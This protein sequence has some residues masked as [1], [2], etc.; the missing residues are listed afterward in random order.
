MV[1]NFWSPST[2]CWSLIYLIFSLSHTVSRKFHVP[3]CRELDQWKCRTIETL[4]NFNGFFLYV[5]ANV[6]YFCL[7]M[8]KEHTS[9]EC[10]TLCS[11]VDRGP[12]FYCRH[13]SI[14][15]TCPANLLFR[16]MVVYVYCNCDFRVIL[17]FF[18]GNYICHI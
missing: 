7:Y 15:D 14:D 1:T 2:K 11:N 17:F 13:G 4:L 16:L 6:L 5:I 9:V 8:D 12:F 10:S 3:T 18:H